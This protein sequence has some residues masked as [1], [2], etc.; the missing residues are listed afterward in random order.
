MVGSE[1]R[2]LDILSTVVPQNA[3]TPT[4]QRAFSTISEALATDFV[5]AVYRELKNNPTAGDTLFALVE[6]AHV[7]DAPLASWISE[8][9]TTSKW[10]EERGRRAKLAD[11]IDYVS[12]AVEG[13]SL[14]QGHSVE[15]YLSNYG[16]ERSEP[17]R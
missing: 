5:R 11:M 4:A 9:V 10:L 3:L 15:W 8:I 6:S 17:L 14:Q 16:F 2:V 13:S 12:C 1:S 7:S